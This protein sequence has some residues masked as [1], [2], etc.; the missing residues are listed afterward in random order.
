MLI[1]RRPALGGQAVAAAAPV[2]GPGARGRR[3]CCCSA[4]TATSS[5][6]ASTR[7]SRRSPSSRAAARASACCCAASPRPTWRASSSSPPGR[8]PPSALVEAVY[9]E[10]EG[11]PFF[12]HEVVQLL[13][14]DGRLE[15]PEDV[16]SWSVEIPQGVRQVVGRRLNALSEDCNRVLGDR[17]GDRARV[18][19]AACSRAVSELSEDGAPGAAR[20]GRGRAHRRRGRGGLRELP[21]LARAGAR[22]ALRGD[23][24][25]AAPAP[26]PPHRRGARGAPRGEARAAPGRARLPLLRGGLGRRRRQGRR[27]RRARRRAGH[28]LLA[29]EEAAN[30]YE[31]ALT[32]LEASEPVDETRRCELLLALGDAQ[33]CS[34]TPAYRADLPQ[35]SIALA[36]Q[37]RLSGALRACRDRD[38]S[39]LGTPASSTRT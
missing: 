16:A 9:R 23:P 38:P 25:H 21:L 27:L 15:R 20:G 6:G 33:L 7:S 26:A 32:A 1:A 37:T 31:R 36:R 24:H 2:P 13:Q 4:P 10:T 17:L 12:V 19:A 5:S 28:R 34:G 8:A 29:F 35:R 30:H 14:S 22:D 3:A 39:R 11:N 18:R